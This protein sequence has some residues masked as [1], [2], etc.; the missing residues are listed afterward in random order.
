MTNEE[1]EQQLEKFVDG[2]AAIKKKYIGQECSRE[3]AH[4]MGVE[5]NEFFGTLGWDY[6]INISFKFTS[7]V[8]EPVRLI[9]H[10]I[11]IGLKQANL[12]F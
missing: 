3:L 9:D 2:I 8:I 7:M 10:F 12:N 5:L 11:T 6:R 4:A 1:Q